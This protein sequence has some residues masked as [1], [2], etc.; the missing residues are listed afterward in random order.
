MTQF[1]FKF[2]YRIDGCDGGLI[3]DFWSFGVFTTV[4]DRVRT[5]QKRP[6]QSR[7]DQTSVNQ[8]RPEHSTKDL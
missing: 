1:T 5:V 7:A 6:K 3:V 8:T 2:Q 4:R